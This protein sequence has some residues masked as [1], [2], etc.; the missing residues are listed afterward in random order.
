VTPH[1]SAVTRQFWRREMDLVVE[2]FR[3][4]IAGLPLLNEVQPDRGY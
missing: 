1:V 2:N 4:H 3:R